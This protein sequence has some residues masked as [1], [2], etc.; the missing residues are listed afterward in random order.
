MHDEKNPIDLTSDGSEKSL[1]KPGSWFAKIDFINHLILLNN[2]L[3]NVL[4]EKEG[5]KTSFSTL[6]HTNLDAQINSIALLAEPGC[7]KKEIINLIVKQ[8]QL[9]SEFTDINS[10][11]TEVNQGKTHS[12]V[13][14]DDAHNLP[15]DL[16]KES[17]EAIKSQDAFGFF[18]F[19]FISNHSIADKLHALSSQSSNEI[20]HTIELSALNE[21]ETRT[22]VLQR[23]IE[24]KLI[25]SMPSD[26]QFKQFYQ[27]TKGNLSEINAQ[28]ESFNFNCSKASVPKKLFFIKCA[29]AA[30]CAIFVLGATFWHFNS[31]TDAQNQSLETAS[32]IPSVAEVLTQSEIAS[33]QF[34]QVPYLYEN[35]KVVG[36]VQFGLNPLDELNDNEETKT[37]ALIDKVIVIPKIEAP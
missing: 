28:L 21:S 34:T 17:I 15:E 5:G 36:L 19:C 24:K 22:Y 35:A 14:I 6:L 12:L 4:S 37:V 18:H 10:L 2:V 1:F 29:S 9:K 32:L 20:I 16:I 33:V 7:T 13:I 8:L 25:E 27:L 31:V 3:I 26:Q 23:L 30:V 11:F